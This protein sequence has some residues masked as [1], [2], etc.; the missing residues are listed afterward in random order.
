M[1]LRKNVQEIV[2]KVCCLSIFICFFYGVSSAQVD[3]NSKKVSFQNEIV[4]FGGEPLNGYI[5]ICSEEDSYTM[6]GGEISSGLESRPLVN[7]GPEYMVL[8][9]KYD[10]TNGLMTNVSLVND[11]VRHVSYIFP[12]NNR[13][14]SF[15]SEYPNSRVFVF[16]RK[17]DQDSYVIEQYE[18]TNDQALIVRQSFLKGKV[19]I[20]KH[21]YKNINLRQIQDTLLITFFS[22]EASNNDRTTVQEQKYIVDRTLVKR[23]LYDDGELKTIMYY[24]NGKLDHTIHPGS[25]EMFG[26]NYFN[27]G[28][29]KRSEFN[30]FIN[31]YNYNEEKYTS[32]PIN[33]INKYNQGKLNSVQY[34]KENNVILDVPM[35]DYGFNGPTKIIT[36]Q[37]IY[38]FTYAKGL[39]RGKVIISLEDS[40]DLI[41]EKYFINEHGQIEELE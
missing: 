22:Y 7:G 1:E 2:I 4:L 6:K 36:D 20:E 12:F 21:N 3:I 39:P 10:F 41:H 27:N 28:I 9:L 24:K 14:F 8:R 5:I 31:E 25:K 38:E 40:P 34:M 30:Q 19:S 15:N 35:D 32:I 17:S 33:Y 16:S 18:N 13:S 37:Y 23:E 29:L 26:V 11:N